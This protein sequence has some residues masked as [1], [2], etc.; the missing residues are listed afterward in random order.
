MSIKN[1]RTL[2]ITIA[3]CALVMLPLLATAQTTI[4]YAGGGV[5]Q[6][7]DVWE[8]FLPQGF[9][10]CYSDASAYTTLGWRTFLRMGNFDR[11]WTTPGTHWPAAYP[12]TP[13]WFKNAMVFVYD[14]S[15][16]FNPAT[17]EGLMCRHLLSVGWRGEVFDCD[18]NQMLGWVWGNG[19]PVR[20]WELDPAQIAQRQIDRRTLL[21]LHRRGGFQLRRRAGREPRSLGLAGGRKCPSMSF[22]AK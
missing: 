2:L 22:R 9:V 10:P 18:F 11:G 16:T 21:R 5:I 19:H 6:A 8:S 13:Y 4:G 7:G 17:I 20:L 15:S 3:V 14:T 12:M 1:Q